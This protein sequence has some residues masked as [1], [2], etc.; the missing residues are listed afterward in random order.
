MKLN[1]IH[2]NNQWVKGKNLKYLERNKNGN[3]IY[4]NLPD[5]A[6]AVLTGKLKVMKAYIQ[7]EKTSPIHNLTIPQ[8]TIK[9]TN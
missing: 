2:L 6:K 8:G 9:R 1:N 7:K 5:A 3:T 4:Q